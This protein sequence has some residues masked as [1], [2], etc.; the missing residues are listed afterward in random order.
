MFSNRSLPLIRFH[1]AALYD[2]SFSRRLC[3]LSLT[4]P[5]IWLSVTIIVILL[6]VASIPVVVLVLPPVHPAT[7]LVVI[8]RMILD[9]SCFWI[10]CSVSNGNGNRITSNRTVTLEHASRGH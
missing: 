5:K 4:G 9:V 7:T 3:D 8:S 6:R 1:L 2:H 10:S